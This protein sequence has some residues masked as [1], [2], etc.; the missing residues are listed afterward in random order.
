MPPIVRCPGTR[1]N[2]WSDEWWWHK[3]LVHQT[4]TP[5]HK[6]RRKRGSIEPGAAAAKVQRGWPLLQ[7]LPTLQKNSFWPAPLVQAFCRAPHKHTKWT[8]GYHLNFSMQSF[9]IRTSGGTVCR[10][11]GWFL[12]LCPVPFHHPTQ[13]LV[14]LLLVVWLGEC[15]RGFSE[16]RTPFKG[17]KVALQ[18]SKNTGKNTNCELWTALCSPLEDGVATPSVS[19]SVSGSP[20]ARTNPAKGCNQPSA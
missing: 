1:K 7:P 14:P 17:C 19:R 10:T 15:C 8:T 18:P 11:L 2:V 6:A 12:Q 16:N 4:H 9:R 13:H 5:N 20:S 3:T